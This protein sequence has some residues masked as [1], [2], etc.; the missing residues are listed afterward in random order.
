MKRKDVHTK[1]I[2]RFGSVIDLKRKPVRSSSIYLRNSEHCRGKKP[3][4]GHL[5]VLRSECHG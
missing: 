1:L 4:C 2:E 3:A 5:P